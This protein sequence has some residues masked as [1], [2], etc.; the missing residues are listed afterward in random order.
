[1]ASYNPNISNGTCFYAE[2]TETN[3][4]FVPC[5][6]NAIQVWPCC[7]LGSVCLSLGDANA[8]W[9][10]T[11]GNTYVAGCTDPSFASPNCLHK[12]PKF[13]EQEWVAINQACKNLNKNSALDGITNWTGCV[14]DNNSTELVKLPLASCTPHCSA[15]DVLYAG[16][17]KLEAF[18]SLP[19]IKGSSVFWLENFVPPAT[20]APGYT[21]GTAD[22]VVPTFIPTSTPSPSGPPPPPPDSGGLSTGAKA[23]IGVGAAIGGLLLIAVLSSLLITCLR[24]RRQQGQQQQQ[25]HD[26]NN[27]PPPT[28]AGYANHSFNPHSPDTTT[29]A[30]NSSGYPSPPLPYS[31]TYNHHNMGPP[32]GYKPSQSPAGAYTGYKIELPADERSQSHNY[33][34]G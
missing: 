19:T 6:N 33:E 17:S 8:C 23:G 27:M 4:R 2:N 14:I 24:R 29:Y 1:M 34:V 7:Q 32:M 11:T 26:P 9:D 13:H 31:P 21:P 18:A 10:P 5:G 28:T 15:T 16:P 30:S 25:D 3:G 12:P 20:P 22:P